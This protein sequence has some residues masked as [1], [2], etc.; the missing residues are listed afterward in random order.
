MHTSI[1][2]YK[3]ACMKRT[4]V[5][6]YIPLHDCLHYIQTQANMEH[7]ATFINLDVST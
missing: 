1:H 3:H 5:I 4:S 7:G 2:A 6:H